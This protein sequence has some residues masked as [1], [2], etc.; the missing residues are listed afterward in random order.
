MMIGLAQFHVLS[1]SLPP[2][3]W[4]QLISNGYD[5]ESYQ[6]EGDHDTGP[7]ALN[8]HEGQEPN[9]PDLSR[10]RQ[11]LNDSQDESSSEVK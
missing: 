10:V 7:F 5:R 2:A 6:I 1:P 4:D 3:L 9:T 8:E 11:N